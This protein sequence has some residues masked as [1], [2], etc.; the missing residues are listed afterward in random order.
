MERMRLESEEPPPGEEKLVLWQR[1]EPL[2]S[3]GSVGLWRVTLEEGGSALLQIYPE[4]RRG[5]ARRRFAAAAERRARLAEHPCLVAVTG[6][7]LGGRADVM[8][9]DTAGEPLPRLLDRGALS[10]ETAT[11]VFRDVVDALDALDRSGLPPVDLSP[12]D[13]LVVGDRGLLLGDVGLYA[14][15]FGGRCRDLDHAAPERVAADG[16]LAEGP[17]GQLIGRASSRRALRPTPESMGYS[18]ASV[19]LAALTD[20][21]GS[22]P[23]DTD[24]DRLAQLAPGLRHV[25]DRALSDDP[26]RRYRTPA[27]VMDA[28]EAAVALEEP[29]GQTV[30]YL[31]RGR[32][33]PPRPAWLIGGGVLAAAIA[34]A[35][36]G[37][38]T[39][40]DP[41]GPATLAGN[42]LGIDAPAGW[43]R[44]PAN[45]APFDAGPDALVARPAS[46]PRAS[47]T[48]TRSGEALLAGLADVEPDAVDLAGHA[49]W[50]YPGAELGDGTADVYAIETSAGPIVATCQAPETA[51]GLLATCGG[52]LAT[53]TVRDAHVLPLGGDGDSRTELADTLSALRRDRGRGR[54]ALAA[55]ERPYGQ[56]IAA[57]RLA[58]AFA[59]AAAAVSALDAMGPPGAQARLISALDA[60]EGAYG[61]LASAARDRSS[62]SYR[63]ATRK[64]ADGEREV[65]D[66]VAALSLA[67]D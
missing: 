36:I 37:M 38:A 45:T 33:S 56:A 50:H 28:L 11:S 5:H 58:R 62:A 29:P 42:G 48:A 26:R 63:L 3:G 17:V 66:A 21:S 1:A 57:E 67:A 14:E 27:M 16:A 34:G 35:A 31:P 51:R 15:T 47:L 23:E 9:E 64:V 43:S 46:E 20:T 52:A 55:A 13:I 49:A 30:A 18:F 24:G 61:S 7:D 32:R 6:V 60:T 65:S 44:A 22:V 54:Q 53:L 59:R 19:L 39:A 12:A 8:L 41:A 40:S 10:P 2:A 25:F 4:I